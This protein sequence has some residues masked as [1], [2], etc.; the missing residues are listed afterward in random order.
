MCN[1]KGCGKCSDEN[2]DVCGQCLPKYE[3]DEA[4]GWCMAICNDNNCA[5]C[6]DNPDVCASCSPGF[7]LKDGICTGKT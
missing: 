6:E 4:T 7:F 1:V 2:P 5:N 3:L